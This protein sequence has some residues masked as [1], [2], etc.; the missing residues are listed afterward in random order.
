MVC[1]LFIL[2]FSSHA[3]ASFTGDTWAEAREKGSAEITAVY[4]EE[5]SFAYTVDGQLTGV[6]IDIFEQFATW[7]KNSKGVDLSINYVKETGFNTFYTMVKESKGG[8]FGLGSVTILERRRAEVQFSEPFINNIAVLVTHESAT[9][10]DS[11][12]EISKVYEDMVGIAPVG[13][14]L[15]GYM[16]D[17]Q[18]KYYPNLTIN[19]IDSHQDVLKNIISNPK[20]FAYMDLSMFWPAYKKQGEPIKRQAVGDLSAEQFGFIMPLDS[21][22]SVVIDEFFSIGGGYRSTSSYRSILMKNLGTEVL[23]MLDLA[24]KRENRR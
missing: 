24:Q 10:L 13:T 21:D 15:E 4:L 8:V 1:G 11:M 6:E 22:W 20:A 19:H 12:S 5:D 23:Q 9:D 3:Q 7:V 16:E 18:A 2:V 17:L 14:T